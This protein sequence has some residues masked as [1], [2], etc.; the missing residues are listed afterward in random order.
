MLT[1]PVWEH[2]IA[3]LIL[4][5]Q[6]LSAHPAAWT[7]STVTDDMLLDQGTCYF[8]DHSLTSWDVI[9]DQVLLFDIQNVNVLF[10]QYNDAVIIWYLDTNYDFEVLD[11]D[12]QENDLG[13]TLPN[14]TQTGGDSVTAFDVYGYGT[15]LVAYGDI[16]ADSG[17]LVNLAELTDISLPD[18]RGEFGQLRLRGPLTSG[19]RIRTHL[20]ITNIGGMPTAFKQVI[21]IYISLR[22]CDATDEDQDV[23]MTTLEDVKVSKLAPGN[24]KRVGFSLNLPILSEGGEYKFA[25]KIDS[26]GDVT[27][28]DETNNEVVSD[29]FVIE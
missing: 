6:D 14:V 3:I 22:P 15:G 16:D 25:A 20:L 5:I 26:S 19:D 12:G 8:V 29:C 18:L 17:E 1:L 2:L 4:W 13:I 9:N 27:E 10:S 24:S 11:F 23:Y 21:D 7:F 28:Y